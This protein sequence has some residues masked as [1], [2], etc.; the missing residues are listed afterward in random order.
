[1]SRHS[2]SIALLAT[3]FW[4]MHPLHV[5][6]VTYIVQRMASMAAMFYLMAMFFYLLARTAEKKSHR[7]IY[8]VASALASCLALGTKEN[9]A[10]LPIALALYEL[11][12]FR[13][14]SREIQGRLIKSGIILLVLAII[15]GW[16]FID[17]AKLL[18]GYRI[19][20]FT[21]RERLLTEPRVI[22]FYI[23]LLLYPLSSRFVLLHDIDLSRSFFFP[24]TTAPAM[25]LLF[26]IITFAIV[27]AR[28]KPLFAFC[29][30]FFFLNH[31]I[32]GS[33]LSLEVVYE[34]RNYLPSL[35][36][37]V[38]IAVLIVKGLEHFSGR[39]AVVISLAA[40]CVT[41]LMVE[42]VAVVIYNDT[43]KNELTFWL[44]NTE[45]SPL[46]HRPHHNLA[47]E[48]MRRGL[49]PA[50]YAEFQQALDGKDT[51]ATFE[52]YNAHFSLGQCYR[53]MGKDDQALEQFAECI[54]LFS[55][56]PD[57]YQA[58]AEI[59]LA[60][61]RYD[62]AEKAIRHA[63]Y[64]NSRIPSFHLTYGEI[65]LK[66]RTYGSALA[67]VRKTL[68]LNDSSRKAFRLMS[69][70]FRAQGDALRAAHFGRLAQGR[71]E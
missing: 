65:L 5:S 13:K 44:D 26:I 38:P 50:A 22:L 48:Y 53:I 28:K 14:M 30:L 45:K 55:D 67:E 68:I 61:G 16:L 7:V 46:L 63:L 57:V 15:I 51:S 24:W 52:K 20:P 32:E 42:G 18:D 60:K 69:E 4:A 29:A 40:A 70:I 33:L 43:M 25:L 39:K 2:Y 31:A 21:M 8:F 9:A 59:M 41:F 36:F 47:L 1:M 71:K 62:A 11:L 66:K 37:F 23:S 17:P 3:F 27:S 64:L 56:F 35:L 49:F 12:F 6:A 19:R 54:R 10:T 34:H 58:Q